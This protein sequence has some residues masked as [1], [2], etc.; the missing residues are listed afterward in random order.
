MQSI[1][2]CRLPIVQLLPAQIEV[3]MHKDPPHTHLK[4]GGHAA[5]EGLVE[6]VA[7]AGLQKQGV[8]L[9]YEREFLQLQ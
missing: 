6:G 3:L 7:V 2:E 8:A 4:F 9:L 5:C 1:A